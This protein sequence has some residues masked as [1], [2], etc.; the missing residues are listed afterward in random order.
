MQHSIV[1]IDL[2]GADCGTRT[3]TRAL[4]RRLPLPLGYGGG[5][6]DQESGYGSDAWE[7]AAGRPSQPYPA[8]MSELLSP[9][10]ATLTDTERAV[11]DAVHDLA[12]RGE[13]VRDLAALIRIP[14]VT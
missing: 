2:I 13:I 14:S 5:A 8:A 9:P 4:L 3:R 6:S 10:P 12:R 1:N 11:L 7:R